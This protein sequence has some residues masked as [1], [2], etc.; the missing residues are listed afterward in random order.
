M[1]PLSYKAILKKKGFTP[2]LWSLFLGALNDNAFKMVLSLMAVNSSIV[3]IAQADGTQLYSSGPVALIGAIFILPYLLFSGYAGYFADVWNKRTVLIATK[4][5][6]VIA[7]G[8][9]FIVL[10]KDILWLSMIVLFLMATQSTFFGPAKYGILPEIFS[11][12]ELSRANGLV[13][14]ATFLAIILGTFFGAG[15]LYVWSDRKE[16]IGAVMFSIAI[17]GWLII[18]WAPKVAKSGAETRFPLNP[19]REIFIGAK[20]IFGNERLRLIVTGIGWFWFLGALLQMTLIILSKEILQLDDLHTGLIQTVLALGIG[21]GSLCAGWLSGPRIE[22]GLV[23][24]GALGIGIGAGY[25]AL[26]LPSYTHAIVALFIIGMSGGMFFIPLNAS[27]QNLAGQ[28]EKGTL[29]A[30]SNFIL[31]LGILLASATLHLCHDILGLASDTIVLLFGL[32]TVLATVYAVYL[33]PDVLIRFVLWIFTHSIYRIRTLEIENV[34]KTGSALII[35][36]HLS[37]VDGLLIG[38][39]LDRNVRFMLYGAIYDIWFLKPFFKLMKVIPVRSGKRVLESIRDAQ[40]ALQDGDLVCIFAEGGISRTGNILPFK[41][42][43]EKIAAR[44]EVPIIPVHLDGVWGSIFSFHKKKIFFKWPRHIPYPVTISFGEP[45]IHTATTQEVRQRVVELS[46]QAFPQRAD[47]QTTLARRFVKTSKKR[48]WQVCMMDISRQLTFGHTLTAACLLSDQVHKLCKNEEKIGLLFPASIGGA[49]ANISVSLLGKTPVNLNFTSSQSSLGSAIAQSNLETIITSKKFIEK[50]KLDIPLGNIIY[51]EDLMNHI[52]PLAKLC[53]TIKCTLLPWRVLWWSLPKSPATSDSI[54]TIIFSSGSTGEPKG[55][56]L[57]HQNILCNIEATAQVFPYTRRDRMLGIL[58]FFH[59][60]GFTTTLWFPLIKGLG[61]I[62]HHNPVDAKTIGKLVQKHKA[63]FILSTPTFYRSYIRA[64]SKEQFASLKYAVVGAEKLRSSI[65]QDFKSKF[66]IDLFEGY[67]CT[68]T[69]PVVAI[70]TPDVRHSPGW[71]QKGYKS[72]TV[73]TA[74]PGVATRIVD[75]ETFAAI[76]FGHVGM[77]LV[78][79]GSCM[80]GY[81]NQPEK[82]RQ[83]FIQEGWYITGDMAK[84]D[85]GGFITIVDRLTRFSKIGGEMVPHIKIEEEIN[86]VLEGPLAIVVSIPDEKKGEQLAVIYSHSSLSPQD[87]WQKLNKRDLPKLWLP[88]KANFILVPEL[89]LL[90][91]GKID[92]LQAKK[93]AHLKLA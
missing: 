24:L 41:R 68:E 31:T 2:Y 23:P 46:S 55:I 18:W 13:E 9:A 63:T 48:W 69:G 50:L 3:G 32:L 14:T 75:P 30:T 17:M 74:L 47:V 25:F 28:R 61:V 26:G 22:L 39:A 83:A 16:L 11:T 60:F 51:L 59:S 35:S 4:A 36:N 72:E 56:M 71:I 21:F 20:R 27:L 93:L 7:M 76:P 88:P 82:T 89:P 85:E 81:L 12:E 54:A 57:S 37:Y 86:A 66:D 91:S 53:K 42:G 34:P 5:M 58:P 19:W 1:T 52:T 64:C 49:L 65:A 6:E 87:L 77:L 43:F 33:L 38:A 92:L 62:F 29:I 79:G 70:N 73:G 8:L 45:M 78:K 80:Q 15:L 67:G 90:A 40:L 44:L 84:V 10:P